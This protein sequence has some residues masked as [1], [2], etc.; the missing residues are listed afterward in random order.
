MEELF[1]EKVQELLFNA[2]FDLND[3]G[4][5]SK[6]DNIA[7]INIQNYEANT[8]T[9][10]IYIEY[11]FNPNIY[12]SPFKFTD[13]S[14]H[15]TIP[16]IETPQQLVQAIE[17]QFSTIQSFYDGRL[18]AIYSYFGNLNLQVLAAESDTFENFEWDKVK[19]PEKLA[20][21]KFY[22]TAHDRRYAEENV[23]NLLRIKSNI[24]EGEI[25]ASI[26]FYYNIISG[27]ICFSGYSS[28]EEFE[29]SFGSLAKKYSIEELTSSDFIELFDKELMDIKSDA[30]QSYEDY[31]N[32]N[33]RNF[34]DDYED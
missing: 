7:L 29:Q 10:N 30:D 15:A 14:H 5:I 25:S 17:K 6:P 4:T 28:V 12:E 13:K 20:V 16:N 23:Y 27:E 2:G 21:Y 8:K 11:D 9:A 24:S 31:A 22:W 3:D 34:R 18:A 33:H 32:G 26:T 1:M 19:K